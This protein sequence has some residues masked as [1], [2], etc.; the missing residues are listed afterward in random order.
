MSQ[1]KKSVPS[2]IKGLE[3]QKILNVFTLK[4]KHKHLLLENSNH[5]NVATTQ[6]FGMIVLEIVSKQSKTAR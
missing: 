1:D 2:A 5:I 3:K 4:M 6:T